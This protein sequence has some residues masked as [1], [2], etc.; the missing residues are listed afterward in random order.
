MAWSPI[1]IA[2]IGVMAWQARRQ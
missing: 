2:S 1:Y